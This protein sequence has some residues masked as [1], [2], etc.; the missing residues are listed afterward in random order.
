MP[1]LQVRFPAEREQAQRLGDALEECGAMS[2]SIEHVDS[3]KAWVETDWG[4]TPVWQRSRV[5]A[6]F[7]EHTDVN[8]L[9]SQLRQ[10]G[11][12]PPVPTTYLLADEDW[13]SSWK[14]NYHPLKIS[15]RLW[16][17]P[18]WLAPPDPKAVN[19]I[20]DPGMAFGTGDHPTT[21][22]CLEWLAERDCTNKDVIDYGCGSGILSIAALKLGARSALGI[23]IDPQA[24]DVS[25]RN[26]ELNGVAERFTAYLPES[27]P[28]NSTADIVIAN[29]LARPLVELAPQIRACVRPGGWLALSGM[30]REQEEMVRPHYESQFAFERRQRGDWILLAGQKRH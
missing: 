16:I 26:M 21:A 17:C 10:F 12:E 20:L 3:G 27:L 13:E 25:R 24:L 9:L 30:L 8:Q 23:D 14:E 7:P 15:E 4:E 29:I 5:T 22:L 11:V 18:S 19:V 28:A 2:V 6:L 1:W